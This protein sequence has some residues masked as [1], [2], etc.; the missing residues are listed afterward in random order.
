MGMRK[1]LV[2]TE[3]D[4][5]KRRERLEENRNN[6]LKRS[7]TSKPPN[8]THNVSNSESISQ[9]L[10]EIDRVGFYVSRFTLYIFFS[11]IDGY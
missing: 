11:V 3:E 9:A 4:N 1:D 2:L 10:D 7:T 8:S 5:Q 6:L